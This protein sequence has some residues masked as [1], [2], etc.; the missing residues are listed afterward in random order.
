MPGGQRRSEA[1]CGNEEEQD[2][3][4]TVQVVLN[5]RQIASHMNSYAPHEQERMKNHF[6]WRREPELWKKGAGRDRRVL[7]GEMLPWKYGSPPKAGVPPA[8]RLLRVLVCRAQ[9]NAG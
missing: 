3:N 4:C 9:S 6:T 7:P 5:G 1:G 8:A 2:R